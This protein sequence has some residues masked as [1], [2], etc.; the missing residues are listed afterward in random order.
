MA[1]KKPI[2]IQVSG[3]LVQA[4]MNVPKGVTVQVVDFDTDG[5]DPEDGRLSKWVSDDGKS[6]DCFITEYTFGRDDT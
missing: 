3:G 2:V 1:N 6:E 4:V 5:E